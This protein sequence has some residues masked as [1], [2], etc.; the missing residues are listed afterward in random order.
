VLDVDVDCRPEAV[1]P[2]WAV[3]ASEAGFGGMLTMNRSFRM[4][5]EDVLDERLLVPQRKR[6]II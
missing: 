1:V 5:L 6:Q 2:R 3:E 4:K